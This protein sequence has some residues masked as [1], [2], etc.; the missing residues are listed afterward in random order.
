MVNLRGSHDERIRQEELSTVVDEGET[1][2][3]WGKRVMTTRS[4]LGKG[5]CWSHDT[6]AFLTGLTSAQLSPQSSF[7]LLFPTASA[8]L[9]LMRPRH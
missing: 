1:R 9:F 2:S 4:R 7:H 8:S 5:T 3:K 6:A